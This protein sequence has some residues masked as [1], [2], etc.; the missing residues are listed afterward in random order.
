MWDIT[1]TKYITSSTQIDSMD[2]VEKNKENL[3]K[4]LCPSCPI[5]TKCASVLHEK[6]YCSIAVG[7]SDCFIDTDGCICGN[8]PVQKE[9][10]LTGNHYCL[11]GSA[12]ASRG[13][14]VGS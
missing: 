2:T 1:S 10:E 3:R 11:G 12:K 9:H 8:C 6:L 5:Y 14:E 4:C 7:K 13:G